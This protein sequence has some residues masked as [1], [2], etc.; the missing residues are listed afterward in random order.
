[1][2][3]ILDNNKEATFIRT[4][5]WQQN[6]R[7]KCNTFTRKWREANK[8]KDAQ[9]AAQRRLMIKEQTPLWSNKNYR[10]LWYT[11]AKAEEKR[12]GWKVHVDHIVPLRGEVVCGLHCEDNMQL[13]FA[14]A[15]TV[16]FDADSYIVFLPKVSLENILSN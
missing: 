4:K 7:A 8:D 14:S 13:L 1:M 2:I 3:L 9:R 12:T 10:D 16:L 5:Q 15:Q 11:L 6:N